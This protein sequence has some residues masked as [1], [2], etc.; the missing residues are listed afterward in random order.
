LTDY[1]NGYEQPT[2][3]QAPE[4]APEPRVCPRT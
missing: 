2:Q 3:E 4:A 1:G